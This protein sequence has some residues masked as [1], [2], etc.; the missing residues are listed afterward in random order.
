[1]TQAYPKDLFRFF[2]PS[3]LVKDD[4][5]GRVQ[6]QVDLI[7][8]IEKITSIIARVASHLGAIENDARTLNDFISRLE[9]PPVFK[10]LYS[11]LAAMFSFFGTALLEQ[12]N[13]NVSAFKT[14]LIPALS[15]QKSEFIRANEQCSS[16]LDQYG[17][18]SP[19]TRIDSLPLHENM[20]SSIMQERAGALYAL[21]SSLKA[22]EMGS[23]SSVNLAL[24]S[25]ICSLVKQMGK[26]VKDCS[27]AVDELTQK[28]GEWQTAVKDALLVSPTKDE[29]MEYVKSCWNVRQGIMKPTPDLLHPSGIMWLRYRKLVTNWVRK[30]VVFEDGM[31]N[32]YDPNTGAKDQVFPLALVQIIQYDSS[33]RRFCFKLQSSNVSLRLQTLSKF[34]MDEWEDIMN[35][36]NSSILC[37]SDVK[38]DLP[39]HVCADCGST[40]ATW[41][42]LNWCTY[43]CLK[44]SGVHRQLSTVTSKVRSTILDNLDPLINDMLT[45][46][47]NNAAN[48]LL[49]AKQ[50]DIEVD[51]R[52]EEQLRAL[53]ITRKYQRMDWKSEAKV[54]NPFKAILNLDYFALFHALNFGRSQDLY[55]TLTPLHA[56]A[57][58][59]NPMI[60]AITACCSLDID[61]LDE[62]GWTPLVY[63]VYY[64][65][66]DIV[67]FLIK[68]G[69]Q[70]SQARVDLFTLAVA[71]GNEEIMDLV[72]KNTKFDAS[73]TI[74]KPKSTKF[75]PEKKANLTEIVVSKDAKE[76]A[77][78]LYCVEHQSL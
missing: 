47:T 19:R 36:H 14:I 53:Y 21:E 26:F 27:P 75:A 12:C 13:V 62:N 45:L 76:L 77:N 24:S 46:M 38:N 55:E 50:P 15:S 28:N 10:D 63:A 65:N 44:C 18:I 40:D 39:K 60:L 68:F 59:G 7:Q 70:P 9:L 48:S 8:E 56:A 11:S 34:D 4:V 17:E 58:Y 51:P 5:L 67:K 33:K 30:Y 23:R 37:G 2:D 41:C 73:E 25:F 52:M 16:A 61:P 57:A 78:L 22:A 72:L 6:Q 32:I 49:L 3:P 64:E 35:Q 69:A 66:V 42:S 74:F 31:L 20:L 29:A 1:M 43:L 54:P 71:V